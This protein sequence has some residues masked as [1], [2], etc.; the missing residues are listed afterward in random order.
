MRI[1]FAKS[2]VA[3]TCIACVTL[4]SGALA[5]PLEESRQEAGE[6]IDARPSSG[7][8]FEKRQCADAVKALAATDGKD[9]D[10]FAVYES[11]TCTQI[12]EA[13][14][15]D[16][17]DEMAEMIAMMREEG[18]DYAAQLSLKVAECDRSVDSA[19]LEPV[20]EGKV[21]S[22]R[23]E[24]MELCTANAEVALYAEGIEAMNKARDE[25][26]AAKVAEIEEQNR[27]NE[28]EIAEITA[29]N[30]AEYQRKV[31]EDKAA[32][33]AEMAEW[34]R[35]VALCESG[36]HEYCAKPE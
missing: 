9:A 32:F 1:D 35:K 10:A 27:R 33:E 17:R 6:T 23:T 29:F 18:I 21:R 34:R 11:E 30:E 4:S 15:F 31:A 19:M 28:R 8:S 7:S 5:R 26:H 22:S 13:N 16:V 3:T 20:P 25:R 24:L 36:K 12:R 2:L 14:K